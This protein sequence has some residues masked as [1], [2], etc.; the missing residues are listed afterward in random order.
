M[1]WKTSKEFLEYIF[2]ESFGIGIFNAKGLL[3]DHSPDLRAFLLPQN[4][5]QVLLNRHVSDLFPELVGMKAAFVS[6]KEREMDELYI[7]R[8]FR[9]NLNGKPG[10]V[11]LRVKSFRDGWI[12]VLRDTTSSGE[13][14][15]QITQQRNELEIVSVELERSHKKIDRLLRTFV[16]TAVVDDLLKKNTA[17]LGGEIRMVTILFA[18]LRGYTAWAESHSPEDALASLNQLLTQAFE[19]LNGNGATIN[20]LMGDGFMS[21]FNAPLHQPHH[22]SHALDSARQIARLPGLGGNVRFGVGVNSGHAMT[23][24]VGSH[25]AM[26]YSAIG[27]TTNIAYRFQ[28]LAGAGEALF[29]RTTLELTNQ[30]YKYEFH[31]HFE[32]KGIQEPVPVY[33][34]ID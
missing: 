13:L 21:I 15:Q 11:S 34:L 18:D 3:E 8:I 12:V 24:N 14:E 19:I 33:K 10:Y 2:H 7:G 16:P 27:T 31:G 25:R 32:V 26:D 22:A 1:I 5:P 30:P 28:Q 9:P 23:G 29:G 4:L 6:I 20:Q 17:R